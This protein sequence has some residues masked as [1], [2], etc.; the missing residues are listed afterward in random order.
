MGRARVGMIIGS[1]AVAALWV[2]GPGQAQEKLSAKLNPSG[3]VRIMAGATELGALE[4]NAHGP[5]WAYASQAGATAR[6]SDLPDQAGK[7]FVGTLP[8]PNTDGGA[9]AF[10]ETVKTLPQGLRL[11][12]EVGVTKA[13]QLNG[14][15]VS[16][17]LP[18]AQYGGQPVLISGPDGEPRTVSLPPEQGE[19]TFAGWS[20]AGSKLEV[21]KGTN[22]AL[23]IELQGA[24]DV[25]IQDLRKWKE[26]VFEIRFPAIMEDPPR[27]VAAEDKFH[28]DLTV[29]CAGPV[30]LAGP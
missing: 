17:R 13:L 23:T 15:Q 14:L 28:L 25:M 7:R 24:A 9:L 16:L 30:P 3:L 12:Y 19:N 10:T 18:V 22:Q 26:P 29:T 20:G 8:V 27:P 21:A 5:Q 11:V 4:L 1:V 6:V 2:A